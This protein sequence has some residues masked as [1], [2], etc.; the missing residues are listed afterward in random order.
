MRLIHKESFGLKVYENQFRWGGEG[1]EGGTFSCLVMEN[2]YLKLRKYILYFKSGGHV[3]GYYENGKKICEL[4]I[5][6]QGSH[7]TSYSKMKRA[8]ELTYYKV[9]GSHTLII[10]KRKA[11]AFLNSKECIC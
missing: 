5:G 9:R 7:Y 10:C 4:V 3:F 2:L 11:R 8:C 6:K 1:G